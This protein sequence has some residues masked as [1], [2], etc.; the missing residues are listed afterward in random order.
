METGIRNDQ[1]DNKTKSSKY[2]K[3]NQRNGI[4]NQNL[5][6]IYYTNDIGNFRC[7]TEQTSRLIDI[8]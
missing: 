7:D 5:H 1:K 3:S 2:N 4:I 8:K 6:Y